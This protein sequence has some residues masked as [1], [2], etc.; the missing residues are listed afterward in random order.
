MQR[1]VTVLCLGVV[2]ISAAFCFTFAQTQEDVDRINKWFEQHKPKEWTPKIGEIQK[3]GE[4]Q[5][6]KGLQV[7]KVE[8]AKCERRFNDVA[9]RRYLA[10]DGAFHQG[11]CRWILA[12]SASRSFPSEF[13]RCGPGHASRTCPPTG[14]PERAGTTI[15]IATEALGP[16]RQQ[17]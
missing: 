11:L 2:C 9:S 1:A 14:D 5:Q 3:P 15:V 10:V 12:M 7:I 16:R 17:T 13:R 6:P 4:I 8:D